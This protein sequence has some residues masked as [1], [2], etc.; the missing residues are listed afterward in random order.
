M[1]AKYSLRTQYDATHPITV[2]DIFADKLADSFLLST[3]TGELVKQVALIALDYFVKYYGAE[4]VIGG[5][6]YIQSLEKKIIDA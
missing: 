2:L 5:A 4:N 1:S 3:E 6:D